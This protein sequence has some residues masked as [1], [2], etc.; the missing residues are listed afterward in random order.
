[1]KLPKLPRRPLARIPDLYD[2]DDDEPARGG[3]VISIDPDATP[4]HLT[5]PI[6]AMRQDRL[7]VNAPPELLVPGQYYLIGG[8]GEPGCEVVQV[9]PQG[10]EPG[11]PRRIRRGML[12][13]VAF[14]HPAGTPVRA[15]TARFV[16]D[17]A[18]EDLDDRSAE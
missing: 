17:W 13:T 9:D 12:K 1:M 8:P 6:M 10:W 5:A 11:Q 14:T 3:Y 4:M 16:P 15:V 7:V 18:R 2:E